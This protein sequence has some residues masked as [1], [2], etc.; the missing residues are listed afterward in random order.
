MIYKIGL[1]SIKIYKQKRLYPA[2]NMT[3]ND[4]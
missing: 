3:L 2:F 4:S 1:S